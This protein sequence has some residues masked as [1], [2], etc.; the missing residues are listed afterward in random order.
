MTTTTLR[1]PTPVPGI[2]LQAATSG[3]IVTLRLWHDRARQR[4]QLAELPP[5]RLVD[6][7]ASPAEVRLEAAKPFWQ[8]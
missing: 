8:V 1:H 5:E 2:S 3:A 6:I 7:G 4:R